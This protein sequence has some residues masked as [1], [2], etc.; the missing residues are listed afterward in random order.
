[1]DA[2]LF[3]FRFKIHI[4]PVR[5]MVC[6]LMVHQIFFFNDSSEL[7]EIMFDGG[8]FYSL[9]VFGE[10]LFP[11][12]LDE[13]LFRGNWLLCCVCKEYCAWYWSSG[14]SMML[15][16]ILYKMVIIFYFSS[17]LK[18]F[19][20]YVKEEPKWS[21]V[22]LCM[23]YYYISIHNNREIYVQNASTS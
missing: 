22:R 5:M 9:A 20:S 13:C 3:L 7:L 14:M 17:S 21:L 15:N 10:K 16:S 4:T 1:M 23:C 11:N 12:V 2:A 18:G 19:V 6:R 8:A